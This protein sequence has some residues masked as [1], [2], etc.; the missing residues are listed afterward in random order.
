MLKHWGG[1]SAGLAEPP[2]RR[3]A[4]EDLLLEAEERLMSATSGKAGGLTEVERLKAARPFGQMFH[5][6]FPK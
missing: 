4:Q 2:R 6:P 1:I 5:R 3:K